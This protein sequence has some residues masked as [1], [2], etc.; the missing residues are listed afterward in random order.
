MYQRIGKLTIGSGNATD[1][2]QRIQSDLS[3]LVESASGFI[4]YTVVKIDDQTVITMRLFRDLASM[5]SE[6]QSTNQTSTSIATDFQLTLDSLV[7]ADTNIGIASVL[8]E[9]FQP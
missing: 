8:T 4:A 9:A 7:D 2:I 6:T 5:D 3:P 1:L